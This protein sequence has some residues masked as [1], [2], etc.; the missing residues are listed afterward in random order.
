MKI[1]SLRRLAM[2]GALSVAGLS[3]IGM[4]AN[5]V[6]TV[7][8]TGNQQIA[9]GTASVAISSPSTT[10]C[11]AVTSTC[12]SLTLPMVTPTTPSFTTGDQP[13]TVTNTGNIA[14]TGLNLRFAVTDPTSVLASEVYVCVGT[15]GVGTGANFDRIW[16]G[17]LSGLVAGFF[18][19]SGSPLM[20]AGS[21]PAAGP[22]DNFTV[23]IYAGP[24][25]ATACGTSTA[26][27]LSADAQT[28]SI[29]LTSNFTFQG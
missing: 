10:G 18:T 2:A 21:P 12:T 14:L 27:A 19:Q 15:T 24:G 9:T 5:A 23:N 29:T 17:P 3:L 25:E 11:A 4:G 16:N 8:A 28:E 13:L 7:Q 6:F 1:L 26:P 20:A 22:T